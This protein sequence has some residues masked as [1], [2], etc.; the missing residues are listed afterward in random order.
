MNNDLLH[1][2]K[3]VFLSFNAAESKSQILHVR[4][5]FTGKTIVDLN[6]KLINLSDYVYAGRDY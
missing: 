3:K 2:I 6:G 1:G 5:K 4:N